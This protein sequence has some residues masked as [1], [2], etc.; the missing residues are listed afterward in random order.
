MFLIISAIIF[1]ILYKLPLEVNGN[2]LWCD[3]SG[4]VLTAALMVGTGA[5]QAN[6]Q[7]KQG[8]AQKR[9][10]DA[11]AETSRM[12]GDAQLAIAQKNAEISEDVGSQQVKAEAV[13][14]AEAQ[15]YQKAVEASNG[16]AGSGTAQDIAIDS[17]RKTTQNEV[18]LKYNADTKAWSFETEGAY[19]KWGAYEQANQYNAAGKQALGAAKRAATTTMLSTAT[20]VATFGF[21]SGFFASG[22]KTGIGAANTVKGPGAFA[23]TGMLQ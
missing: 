1:I 17:M 3:P 18:N 4:G 13:K 21:N 23:S 6:N 19:N 8:Q 15:G 14:G 2:R 5:M 10:Y 7:V 22:A 20:S 16:I 9:Y 11:M 12:Q